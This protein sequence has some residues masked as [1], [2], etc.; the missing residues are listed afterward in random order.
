MVVATIVKYSFYLINLLFL[1]DLDYLSN[2]TR[3]LPNSYIYL[4]VILYK[5]GLGIKENNKRKNNK[6]SFCQSY[7][8]TLLTFWP[9]FLI[10]SYLTNKI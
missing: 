9:K 8:Y 4:L 10:N 1:H 7:I 5:I 6:L 2:K 3:Y